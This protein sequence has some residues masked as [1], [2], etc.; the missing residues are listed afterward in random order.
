LAQ[1]V[2][3]NCSGGDCDFT[4]DALQGAP[5]PL[6]VVYL[7]N[8][9]CC[10]FGAYG[11][12]VNAKLYVGDDCLAQQGIETEEELS[13]HRL[14]LL[15]PG[16]VCDGDDQSFPVEAK[17]HGLRAQTFAR[18]ALP[19]DERCG[20]QDFLRLASSAQQLRQ[21]SDQIV[22]RNILSSIDLAIEQM[23]QWLGESIFVSVMENEH[24]L[25]AYE[26]GRGLKEMAMEKLWLASG[27]ARR[28][29][30]LRAVGWPFEAL[31]M[32]ID[33]KLV[34]GEGALAMVERL[35]L[36]K[37]Q[38][39]ART[40]PRGLVLGADTTVVVDSEILVK[41]EDE[42]DARRMLRLLSGR[43]HEVLTGVALLR[44][45]S[46]SAPLVAHERTQVRFSVLS[47]EEINWYIQSAEPMGK[48]G[49]YAVQGRAALFV[50]EIRGDYWNIVGLPVSQ[51]YR[52]ASRI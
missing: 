29:E 7:F 34:P 20:F 36:E 48:A 6:C 1:L 3:V 31:P 25:Q 27:S 12:R 23:E 4:G 9:R 28:A 32:D 24:E 47:E 43:W 46:E 52:L 33:E 50:E 42:R 30:I 16:G 8:V 22:H 21:C 51:V 40:C 2:I 5:L 17:G 45:G 18:D 35:A 37:A 44:A 13:A 10:A 49:A 11:L 41:P 14:K 15:L 39:A 26:A 38:A 19:R